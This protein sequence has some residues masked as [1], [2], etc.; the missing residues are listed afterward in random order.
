M[1]DHNST[2]AHHGHH[3]TSIWILGRTFLLLALLMG[4]T[5]GAAE[6]PK[7]FAGLSWMLENS[8]LMNMIALT[9]AVIKAVLVISIFMGLKYSSKLT[10]LYALGG[11]VWL[12]L[13]GIT[14][15]D[16]YSRPWEPVVG[17]D[18]EHSTALPR[19]RQA[20]E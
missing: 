6:I 16:Y 13:M 17:W 4:L 19:N 8:L 10:K 2:Q 7:S 3:I 12:T 1:A 18:A 11:F 9:I 5:I 14:L 20:K 15:I